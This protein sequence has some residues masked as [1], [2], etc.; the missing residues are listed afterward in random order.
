MKIREPRRRPAAAWP[1]VLGAVLLAALAVLFA[2][3]TAAERG[4]T[5]QPSWLREAL[6][7][8]H[9][10]EPSVWVL[11]AGVA[12]ALLGLWFLVAA[13]VPARRSHLSAEGP[14]DLWISPRAVE[15][16]AADAAERAPGVLHAATELRRRRLKVKALLAPGHEAAVADILESVGDRLAGLADLEVAVQ[17]KE[18][19]R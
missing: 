6:A 3:H 12:S 13:F 2:Q 14:G 4:W 18:G 16:M 11:A 5:A 9:D 7:A 15:A 17:A 19:G 1:A 8:L 10:R